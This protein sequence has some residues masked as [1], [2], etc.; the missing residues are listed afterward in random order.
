MVKEINRDDLEFILESGRMGTW[1]I[2]LE[3]DSVSCSKVML[4][5]WGYEQDS[6]CGD[7]FLLQKKVHQEDI[8]LM[9]RAIAEA[10]EQGSIYELEYRIFP[11]PGIERWV[12][13]RG[14]C[15]YED[16]K[17]KPVRLSGVVFDI[18][19]KKLREIELNRVLKERDEFYVRVSH[20]V[21]NPLSCMSLQL[22]VMDWKLKNAA[23]VEENIAD[24]IQKQREQLSR[25][26]TIMKEILEETKPKR[27]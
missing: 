14:R 15:T 1:E 26:T 9:R 11:E 23:A 2:D 20:E 5:I 27:N 22:E 10:I 13:S 6:H 7:R 21:R 8:E 4:S 12:L 3:D 16:G 24:Y 17:E 25:L 19:E 18:T